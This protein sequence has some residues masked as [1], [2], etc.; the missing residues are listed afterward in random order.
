MSIEAVKSAKRAFEVMEC[1]AE[2]RRAMTG[3]EIALTLD[4]P[5]SSTNVLLKS[6]V[7]MGYLHIDI[8]NKTYFPTVRLA[9]ISGWVPS[10]FHGPLDINDI[11]DEIRMR[12]G[13]TVTL[14]VQA[15]LNM[16][17][18]RVVPGVEPISGDIKS[19]S[20]APVF[21][22]SVGLALLS[23]MRDE[24]IVGMLKRTR[25]SKAAIRSQWTSLQSQLTRIRRYGYA[26]MYDAVAPDTGA[27]S[28]V[29]PT[30][31][32]GRPVVLGVGGSSSRIQRNEASI[33]HILND[34]V[35]RSAMAIHQ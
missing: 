13:E 22:S 1:F 32:P 8:T 29:L 6:L 30:K 14:S 16:I 3:T 23:S 18:V 27:L 5:K 2:Y 4:Y 28:V 17:F 7:A 25:T 15:E 24:H 11:V 19:G 10:T 33:A 9:T 21:E 20:Y 34:V 12:T 31:E 35:H 26:T